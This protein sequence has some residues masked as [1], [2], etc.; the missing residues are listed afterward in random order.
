MHRIGSSFCMLVLT[1]ALAAACGELPKSIDS[2]ASSII[3]INSMVTI[4]PSTPLSQSLRNELTAIGKMTG[5]CTAFH[6]GHGIVATAGHCITIAT[7]DPVETSC[8]NLSIVWEQD[9]GNQLPAHSRCM[10][11]LQY[12]FDVNGDFAF[13]QVDPAPA[14]SIGIQSMDRSINVDQKVVVVGYPKGKALSVS[15]RCEMITASGEASNFFHHS[16]DTL[17]GNSGSPVLDAD[18]SLVLGIHNGDADNHENYGS[19]LPDPTELQRLA[20]L[21]EAPPQQFSQLHYG[22]F[23]DQWTRNL[24]NVTTK[25]ATAVSFDLKYNVEDGY[26]KLVIVDGLGRVV[27][28]TGDHLQHFEKLPTPLSLVVITDYSGTSQSVQLASLVFE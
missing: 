1:L 20:E 28:L 14:A 16:C 6:L 15:G 27:E 10:K 25:E 8:H 23:P 17:P 18:S 2:S 11:I 12:Q 3:D 4:D 9:R 5:G 13:I 22:P 7:A 19:Y 26:D 21:V 24:L